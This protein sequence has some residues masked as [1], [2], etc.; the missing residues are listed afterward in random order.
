MVRYMVI[1]FEYVWL[2]ILPL[3]HPFCISCSSRKELMEISLN[4]ISTRHIPILVNQHHCLKYI[5]K[6]LSY[7]VRYFF[8]SWKIM[9]SFLT[10]F[11]V[12][13]WK[14]K[15]CPSLNAGLLSSHIHKTFQF[16]NISFTNKTSK[17][18]DHTFIVMNYCWRVIILQI[19]LALWWQNLTIH[20]QIEW[21]CWL[22]DVDRHTC[23][24]T[25]QWREGI[26]QYVMLIL[27]QY[28]V[29]P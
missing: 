17:S 24:V 25:Y 8:K 20:R 4:M 23:K 22:C 5:K 3:S 10:V 14:I 28:I 13:K 2:Q 9:Y 19:L 16:N 7:L 12:I 27:R 1:L 18:R 21:I 6:Y 26:S 29:T 11:C 15:P